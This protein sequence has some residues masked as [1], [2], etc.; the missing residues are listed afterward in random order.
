MVYI[1]ATGNVPNPVPA[2]ETV[3][4]ESVAL[5]VKVTVPVEPLVLSIFVLV[6][7]TEF[8]VVPVIVGNLL[9][10]FNGNT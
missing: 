9:V 1:P 7:P 4:T 3:N 10:T 8:A 5:G 6:I 2:V